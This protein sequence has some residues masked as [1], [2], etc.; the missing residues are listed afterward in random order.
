[1]KTALLERL[2]EEFQFI[3]DEQI[4]GRTALKLIELVFA[5]PTPSPDTSKIED[6]RATERAACVAFAE[7]L[8]SEQFT[9]N[10]E[11]WWYRKVDEDKVEEYSTGTLYDK[12]PKSLLQ[13]PPSPPLSQE[14]S[15][16][17]K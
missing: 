15:K 16:S 12:W 9:H 6:S 4:S 7:W 14:E 11:G 2:R 3:D 10:G 5:E 8:D 17:T 1:M 13:E